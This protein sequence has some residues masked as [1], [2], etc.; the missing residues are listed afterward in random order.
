MIQWGENNMRYVLERWVFRLQAKV[1]VSEDEEKNCSMREKTRME[2]SR[3]PAEKCDLTYKT[4][5]YLSQ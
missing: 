5:I 4:I 3:V 2:K 1:K